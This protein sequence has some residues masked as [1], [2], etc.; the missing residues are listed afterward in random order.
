[1]H[2]QGIAFMLIVVYKLLSINSRFS[3]KSNFESKRFAFE[4]RF[5][6]TFELVFGTVAPQHPQLL[7]G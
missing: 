4:L 2:P 7:S 5:G 3:R 6:L 1:V